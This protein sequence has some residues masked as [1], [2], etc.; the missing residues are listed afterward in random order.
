MTP[1]FGYN[2]PY[3]TDSRPLRKS[4]LSLRNF[5]IQQLLS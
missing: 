5:A 3:N 4:R 1:P 2:Y